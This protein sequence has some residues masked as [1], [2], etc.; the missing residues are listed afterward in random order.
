[1]SLSIQTNRHFGR[2]TDGTSKVEHRVWKPDT[3]DNEK[4]LDLTNEEI[5]VLL[6]P[7]TIHAVVLHDKHET[8][9]VTATECAKIDE[10]FN[11]FDELYKE[12]NQPFKVYHCYAAKLDPET[13]QY[14][15]DNRVKTITTLLNKRKD[16]RVKRYEWEQGCFYVPMPQQV[17]AGRSRFVEANSFGESKLPPSVTGAHPYAF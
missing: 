11:D 14:C 4:W 6:T 7:K 1:M 16:D 8:G 17:L 2:S 12:Y 5:I 13:G 9:R 3:D 10:L 15:L